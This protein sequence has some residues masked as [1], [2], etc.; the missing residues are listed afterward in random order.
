MNNFSHTQDT[1]EKSKKFHLNLLFI[2]ILNNYSTP[3]KCKQTGH[4]IYL[5]SLSRFISSL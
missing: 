5:P 2:L 1:Q 3:I 4:T